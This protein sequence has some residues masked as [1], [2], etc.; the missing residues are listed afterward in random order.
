MIGAIRRCLIGAI[1]VVSFVPT[2]IADADHGTFAG[3]PVVEVL[4]ELRDPGLE[5]IYSSELL[6]ATL[7]VLAVSINQVKLR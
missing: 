1:L 7:R 5:F 3:R 2:A 6:P 4:L